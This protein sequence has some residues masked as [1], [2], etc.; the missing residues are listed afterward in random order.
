MNG[1][2][3]K[4]PLPEQLRAFALGQLPEG[5]AAEVE[6]HV[7]TCGTC[8]AALRSVPDDT[9]LVRLRAANTSPGA[10]AGDTRGLRAGHTPAEGLDLPRELI[11]HPRYRV[12]RRLGAGGM[13][14]VY[15]AEHRV[16]ERV[17]ALKVLS[18]RLAQEAGAAEKR[19]LTMVG[20]VVGTPDYIAPEQV[21]D[22]RGV[23]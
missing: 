11:D 6:R 2:R 10:L 7:A 19:P 21:A 22:A 8:C 5:D 16:M 3:Q 12:V 9:L 18:A 20:T 1:T 17:V 13:G 14:V 15:L 4:H 23:D